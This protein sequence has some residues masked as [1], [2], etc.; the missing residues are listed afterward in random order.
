[1]RKSLLVLDQGFLINGGVGGS[2][3]S[4]IRFADRLQS[5]FHTVFIC[6]VSNTLSSGIIPFTIAKY[7]LWNR[8]LRSKLLKRLCILT[9]LVYVI[10]LDR[11]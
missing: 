3:R 8:Y 1:M 9:D 4:G 7:F 5:Q 10:E 6:S 11:T 2:V